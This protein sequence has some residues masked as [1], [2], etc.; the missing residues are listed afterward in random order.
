MSLIN[1]AHTVSDIA[2]DIGDF[3]IDIRVAEPRTDEPLEPIRMFTSFGSSCWSC[4][5]TC[6]SNC[7]SGS[8]KFASLGCSC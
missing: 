1:D 3:D 2:F 5:A 4:N 6:Y 7:C 8:G